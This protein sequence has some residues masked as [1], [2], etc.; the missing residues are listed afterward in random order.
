MIKIWKNNNFATYRGIVVSFENHGQTQATWKT[1]RAPPVLFT[2][3]SYGMAL[4]KRIAFVSLLTII[5][6]LTQWLTNTKR[7]MSSWKKMYITRF[8]ECFGK[9]RTHHMERR[10]EVLCILQHRCQY[11]TNL[12]SIETFIPLHFI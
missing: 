9:L 6:L 12:L 7:N 8:R 4:Y 1:R 5:H 3:K 2:F 10:M 11:I